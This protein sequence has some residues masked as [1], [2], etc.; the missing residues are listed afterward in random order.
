M[1]TTSTAHLKING[2]K[3]YSPESTLSEQPRKK[4][5]ILLEEDDLSDQERID[6]EISA[7]T[8]EAP[9][10]SGN[11]GFTINTDFARRF[12]HNKRREEVQKCKFDCLSFK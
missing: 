5:K 2:P 3:R 11:D 9:S 6:T 8:R 7:N 10:Y 4:A 1:A 12:E